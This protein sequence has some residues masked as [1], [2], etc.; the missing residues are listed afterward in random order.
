DARGVINQAKSAVSALVPTTVARPVLHRFHRHSGAAPAERLAGALRS[1][2]RRLVFCLRVDLGAE[3][4]DE[5]EFHWLLHG[6]VARLRGPTLI[7]QPMGT[8]ENRSSHF[9]IQ[10]AQPGSGPSV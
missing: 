9:R 7:S 4:H 2:S 5:F 10:L 8:L 6:E 3:K 1:V